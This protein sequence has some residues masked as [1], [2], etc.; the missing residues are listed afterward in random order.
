MLYQ[1]LDKEILGERLLRL[2]LV[3]HLAHHKRVQYTVRDYTLPGKNDL[4]GQFVRDLFTLTTE[5]IIDK[6]FGGLENAYELLT[7]SQS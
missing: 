7:R 6:W 5:E 4:E 1:K 3:S 2:P